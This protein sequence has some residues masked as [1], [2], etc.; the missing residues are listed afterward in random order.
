MAKGLDKF[1]FFDLNSGTELTPA[2]APIKLQTHV[3]LKIPN[4]SQIGEAVASKT[5]PGFVLSI[6]KDLVADDRPIKFIQFIQFISRS[7]DIDGERVKGVSHYKG[8]SHALHNGTDSEDN[9]WIDGNGPFYQNSI[10]LDSATSNLM[11]DCPNGFQRGFDQLEWPESAGEIKLESSMNDPSTRNH[12]LE[13]LAK[14]QH[15]FTSRA[16][17]TTYAYDTVDNKPLAKIAFDIAFTPSLKPEETMSSAFAKQS[18][19]QGYDQVTIKSSEL[20]DQLEPLHQQIIE[21]SASNWRV[22]ERIPRD[23]ERNIRNA[24]AEPGESFG[25]SALKALLDRAYQRT[26]PAL[27]KSVAGFITASWQPEIPSNTEIKTSAKCMPCT[28]C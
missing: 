28:I 27:L 1:A 7:L 17:F 24:L 22:S 19:G 15:Q 10:A 11:S 21:N 25:E 9:T 14:S 5:Y 18:L 23:Y 16:H 12:T 4:A 20:I 6:N 3:T 2:K 13:T 26:D 8:S